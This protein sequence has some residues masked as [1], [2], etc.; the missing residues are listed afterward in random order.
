MSMN[1]IGP[2]KW[3]F[4]KEEAG[5]SSVTQSNPVENDRLLQTM[6]QMQVYENYLSKDHSPRERE[7]ALMNILKHD[8]HLAHKMQRYYDITKMA[9]PAPDQANE[10]QKIFQQIYDIIGQEGFL[11][12]FKRRSPSCSNWKWSMWPERIGNHFCTIRSAIKNILAFTV[13]GA[14]I[15]LIPSASCPCCAI[16]MG[17]GA[18][19]GC[20]SS[21]CYVLSCANCGDDY[22]ESLKRFMSIRETLKGNTEINM[23]RLVNRAAIHEPVFYAEAIPLGGALG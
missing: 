3:F 8:L 16:N 12:E 7:K 13:C 6:P 5:Y 20:I 18:G 11:E 23:R 14:C 10:F 17:I 22:S 21:S 19:S 4:Y 1:P 15:G 9:S 2:E